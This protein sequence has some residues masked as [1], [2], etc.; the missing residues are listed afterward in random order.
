M[1]EKK[2]TSVDQCSRDGISLLRFDKDS[3][4]MTFDMTFDGGRV[5]K[6]GVHLVDH[7]TRDL[8]AQAGRSTFERRM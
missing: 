3:V 6:T 5:G 1:E 8:H 4:T 7:P 2:R